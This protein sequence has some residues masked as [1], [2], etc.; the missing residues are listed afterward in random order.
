MS[1]EIDESDVRLRS[2][3]IVVKKLEWVTANFMTVASG[4][5]FGDERRVATLTA[6]AGQSQISG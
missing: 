4:R 2:H 5:R 1:D 3:S 6:S